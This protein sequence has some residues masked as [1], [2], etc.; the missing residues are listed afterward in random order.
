MA[1]GKRVPM[2]NRQK[3]LRPLQIYSLYEY[4]P[5]QGHTSL[6]LPPIISTRCTFL[7]IPRP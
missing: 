5:L 3:K 1:D 4:S 2:R 6:H 7:R